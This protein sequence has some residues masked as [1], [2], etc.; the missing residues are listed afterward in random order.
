MSNPIGA[1]CKLPLF[2]CLVSSSF[3]SP[4]I[5]IDRSLVFILYPSVDNP[6]YGSRNLIPPV[7]P[8]EMCPGSGLFLYEFFFLVV[9]V[10]GPREVS[11]F[12]CSI[13]SLI[14]QQVL[15]GSIP[16]GASSREKLGPRPNHVATGALS[17]NLHF[18]RN[19]A[20]CH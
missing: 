8:N 12:L 20:I 9:S 19:Q 16:S 14:P 15:Q 17:A 5:R 2:F 1:Q 4:S 18:S 7:G 3:Q 11:P 6:L 13:L 10:T